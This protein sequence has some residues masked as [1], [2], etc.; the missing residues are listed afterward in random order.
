MKDVV[1]HAQDR[2]TEGLGGDPP[3][4]DPKTPNFLSVAATML[5]SDIALCTRVFMALL[6]FAHD[7][8]NSANSAAWGTPG[9]AMER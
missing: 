9:T 6:S 3:G 7:S 5:W 8:F 2:Q 1:K 4:D